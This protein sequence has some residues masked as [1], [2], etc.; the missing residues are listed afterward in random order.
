MDEY[1]KD[2]ILDLEQLEILQ[3]NTTL[4]TKIFVNSISI[5]QT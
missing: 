4:S 3:L 2:R 5:A 1:I